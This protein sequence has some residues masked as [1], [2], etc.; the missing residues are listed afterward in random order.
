MMNAIMSEPADAQEF[1]VIVHPLDDGSYWAE[2]DGL[3][4]CL[5]QATSYTDILTR[6][7]DAHDACLLVLTPAL[8]AEGGGLKAASLK[9]LHTAGALAGA[10]LAAG[11]QIAA[12]GRYHIVFTTLGRDERISVPTDPETILN[13][14]YLG[15]IRRLFE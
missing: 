1:D 7:R 8:T 9:D 11:W 2:V 3:P 5:T 6:V 10:L 14:G 15:G 13:D 4:G 12:Q